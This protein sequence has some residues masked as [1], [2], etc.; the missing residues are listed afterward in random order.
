ML[1]IF[2][3]LIIATMTKSKKII[4][5]ILSLC[6]LAWWISLAIFYKWENF[7]ASFSLCFAGCWM[8]WTLL[9]PNKDSK[10]QKD[11]MTKK[12]WY[13]ALALTTK[14]YCFI[15]CIVFLANAFFNFLNLIS[16]SNALLCSLYLILFLSRW[17]YAYYIHHPEKTW[18]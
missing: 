2:N 1:Y 16:A 13:T 5:L 12:A 9:T 18:L 11:E 3:I 10:K 4:N 6:L 7:I 14:L 15:L 17:C 8:I